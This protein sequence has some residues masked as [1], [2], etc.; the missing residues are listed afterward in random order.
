MSD[1]G[2]VSLAYKSISD[3]NETRCWHLKWLHDPDFINV[4]LVEMDGF[5]F[6]LKRIKMKHQLL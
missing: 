4:T 2:Q 1:H 3:M 5:F 6:F